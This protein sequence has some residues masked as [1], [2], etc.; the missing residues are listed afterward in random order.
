MNVSNIVTKGFYTFKIV[1]M[2]KNILSILFGVILFSVDGQTIKNTSYLNQ[3]GE[4][5]L[6]LECILPVDLATAWQFFTN[7]KK[8]QKWI[9]PLAHIELK[10]GGYIV[11][12]YDS[13]KNLSDSSSIKLPVLG[14]ID[15]ELIVLKVKLNNNFAASVQNEDEHLQEIIQFQKVDGKQTKVISTMI[16]WGSGSDWEKAYNFFV[17]GNEWTYKELLKNFQ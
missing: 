3:S 2:K 7:D 12:N 1:Q 5:V 13:T 16:G 14:F 8:L 6:R 9:A 10:S 4:K 17:K 11:T 15:R